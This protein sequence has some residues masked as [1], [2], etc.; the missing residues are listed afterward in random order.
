LVQAEIDRQR[1]EREAEWEDDERT[2]IRASLGLQSLTISE[3]KRN[4]EEAKNGPAA[5]AAAAED[6]DN[7]DIYVY[8][9]AD[10][11]ENEAVYSDGDDDDFDNLD[12]RPG[13]HT[14]L[15]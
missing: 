2:A 8:D 9:G 4:I 6:D 3:I 5:T 7:E 10:S 13:V 14:F 1:A 12:V 11:D 15:E